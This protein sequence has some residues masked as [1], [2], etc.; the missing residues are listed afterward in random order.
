V[1]LY[2]LELQLERKSVHMNLGFLELF[3][4]VH[5]RDIRIMFLCSTLNAHGDVSSTATNTTWDGASTVGKSRLN[6]G[7]SMRQR[8]TSQFQQTSYV[9]LFRT[10]CSIK[11]MIFYF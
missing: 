3:K 6:E 7:S 4:V 2:A 1:S 8:G 11:E 10:G 9:V 5:F